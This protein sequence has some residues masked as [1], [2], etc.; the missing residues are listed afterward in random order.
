MLEAINTSADINIFYEAVDFPSLKVF[1]NK[2]NLYHKLN[3]WNQSLAVQVFHED[4]NF[5]HLF[6]SIFFKLFCNVLVL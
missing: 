3:K 1:E 4:F 6:N 2:L 5:I